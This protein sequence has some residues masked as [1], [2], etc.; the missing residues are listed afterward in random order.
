MT[1]TLTD[2]EL[3]RLIATLDVQGARLVR[4]MANQRLRDLGA[5]MS[6]PWH[7][8]TA[9]LPTDQDECKFCGSQRQDHR[10]V[11]DMPFHA[12]IFKNTELQAGLEAGVEF[13]RSQVG[14]GA[15]EID[16]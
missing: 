5:T 14:H 13:E 4:D 11:G 8:P 15:G 2:L 16:G 3:L 10:L 1:D 12:F 9:H 6:S 7:Q